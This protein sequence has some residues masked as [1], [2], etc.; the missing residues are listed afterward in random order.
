MTFAHTTSPPWSLPGC[1]APPDW[2][3][4]RAEL[5][6]AFPWLPVTALDTLDYRV[7]DIRAVHAGGVTTLAA[8]HGDAT[9]LPFDDRSSM[10]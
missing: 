6:D 1:P 9:R 10:S 2:S 5:L 7:A 4:D 8:I 3:L